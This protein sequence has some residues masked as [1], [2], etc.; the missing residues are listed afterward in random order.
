MQNKQKKEYN[1]IVIFYEWGKDMR[2]VYLN[3][4]KN[5]SRKVISKV[6]NVLCKIN[7]P[8]MSALLVISIG[9]ISL[10]INPIIGMADNGDFYRIISSNNVYQ[11]NP[12]DPDLYNKYFIKD[13]GI[14]KYNNDLQIQLISTQS[15][16]I[17]IAVLISR[18][19][20]NNYILDIR[21]MSWMF[22]AAQAAGIYLISKVLCNKIRNYKFKLIIVT[23]I[24]VIFCDTAYL[25]YYNSFYGEA[26]NISFFLLSIGILL[27][28]IEFDKITMGSIILFAITSF[29][30]FGAKQQLAPVGLLIG[31]MILRL[32]VM[33]KKEITEIFYIAITIIFV[34]GSIVFYK[35]I[36]GD[37]QYSN[38]YHSM[39]R[40]MLL[41]QDN[42]KEVADFF[43]I[44]QQFLLLKET[45][46]FDDTSIIDLNDE[47]LIEEYYEKFTTPKILAYYISHPKSLL[48]MIK[49]SFNNSYSIR[50]KAMGNYEK[51]HNK[52]PGSMDYSF[53]LYSTVKE[54]IFTGNIQFT[55]ITIGM[56]LF[57][58]SKKYI[59]AV[60]KGDIQE[61]LKTEVLFYIFLVGLSQ[62]VIS[63]VGAGD[64]DLAKHVFMYNMSFDIIFIYMISAVIKKKGVEN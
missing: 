48:R 21:Y 27:N 2:I 44:D 23:L 62:V 53:A 11:L 51:S 59:K 31:I 26:V 22:L 15:I 9:I 19:I 43:G 28:M 46:Y 24:T 38:R 55:I 6:D 17:R 10:F 1:I 40:G 47:K 18:I 32:S 63:V 5:Q 37:F 8:L 58:E 52:P 13:Y 49:I 35:A 56:F 29:I 61:R 41:Y 3:N 57:I 14:Y 42:P 12:D 25:A 34:I 45:T 20:N 36:T 30:F 54:K 7:Y 60:K 16:F 64:A 33:D 4:M 50:P 39:N